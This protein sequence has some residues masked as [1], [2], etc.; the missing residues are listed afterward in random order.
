[1]EFMQ[2]HKYPFKSR[3]YRYE[4]WL[5]ML[6][7]VVSS[8]MFYPPAFLNE[9]PFWDDKAYINNALIASGRASQKEV[10]GPFAEERPPLFWWFLT[11]LFIIGAPNWIV[12]L[13]SP[14]FTIIGIIGVY[15]LTARIFRNVL[16]GI[17]SSIFLIFSNFFIT[18]TSYILTDSMGAILSILYILCFSLGLLYRPFI[19]LSGPLLAFSIMARDQNLVLIPV[20]I[21]FLLW[22]SN[23]QTKYKLML[24]ILLFI[25]FLPVV[26]LP[27]Y[28]Y[29][30]YISN[31][32]TPL[33]LNTTTPFITVIMTIALGLLITQK[34]S[35]YYLQVKNGIKQSKIIFDILLATFL[36]LSFLYPY[37]YDNN[38]LGEE[39]QIAGKGFLARPI[40]HFIM[41]SQDIAK[42]N[43]PT[44][45]RILLWIIE[46]LKLMT[47]PLLFLAILGSMLIILRRI[48]IIKSLIILAFLSISYII[49]FTHLEA[50]FL[51][52]AIP[53]IAII[54]SY[55]LTELVKKW[56]LVGYITIILTLVFVLFPSQPQIPIPDLSQKPTTVESILILMGTKKREETWLTSYFEYL[57]TLPQSQPRINIAYPTLALSSL[58]L[59]IFII[60]LALKKNEY[61]T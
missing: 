29:L 59:S 30:Q 40:S 48:H 61:I 57:K 26:F 27:I 41:A 10:W 50:R 33:L 47:I 56:K 55:A 25:T 5:I 23:I 12:K 54:A 60:Y 1:M 35:S 51:V 20:T 8:I 31:I 3:M 34:T 49:G 15:I 21:I 52:Q 46:V 28:I 11:G 16:V 13:V 17:L 4:L 44:N 36:C 7:I 18:T 37:F 19:W 32:F 2:K 39:Y 38:R 9:A 42:M 22:I 6:L 53:P 58:I 45:I 43:I 24:L 14:T